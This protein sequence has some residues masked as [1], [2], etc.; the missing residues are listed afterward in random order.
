M[1]STS[2]RRPF[3][4]TSGRAYS[5]SRFSQRSSS[6]STDNRASTCAC[7]GGCPSCRSAPVDKQQEQAATRVAREMLVSP[8]EVPVRSAATLTG[9][10][11]GEV[12]SL[13]DQATATLAESGESLSDA[14]KAYFEPR[15]GNKLDGVRIHRGGEAAAL[16]DDSGSRAFTYGQHIVFGSGQYVPES[17]AT[18]YIL[19]HELAHTVQQQRSGRPQVQHFDDS[20]SGW[21]GGIDDKSAVNVN[22]RYKVFDNGVAIY[23]EAFTG[24][25]HRPSLQL[26]PGK[27]YVVQIVGHVQ[28]FMDN[29]GNNGYS[30]RDI[31][32]DWPVRVDQD[33]TLHILPPG[34][35]LG[36]VYSD[37]PWSIAYSQVTG[38]ETVGV[39]LSISSTR[40]TATAIGGTVGANESVS[41]GGEA[42]GKPLG[43]GGAVNVE[44]GAGSSQEVSVSREVGSASTNHRYLNLMIDLNSERSLDMEGGS[45]VGS[46][47]EELPFETNADDYSGEQYAELVRKFSALDPG[48][49]VFHVRGEGLTIE[50]RG[51]ASSVG[52]TEDN[53]AL[54]QR[55]AEFVAGVARQTLPGARVVIGFEGDTPWVGVPESDDS[56]AHRVAEIRIIDR[57]A[58]LTP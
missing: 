39:G 57:R 44:V 49:D 35:D 54:S 8:A 17:E 27:S 5:P 53:M 42:S 11:S 30:D 21:V 29:W 55:R 9:R 38:S 3:T 22:L 40:T 14:H 56:P 47:T 7:G 34:E 1:Y 15:L 51:Y 13:S 28:L 2:R 16:A 43:V 36:S 25:H 12:S 26:K 37:I 33:G 20:L 4:A 46:H 6:T 41:V 45:I 50:I 31:R 18:R 10:D 19:A 24:V 52:S 32:Y 58:E 23:D 48:D